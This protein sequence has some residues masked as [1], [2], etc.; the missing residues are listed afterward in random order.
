TASDVV[1]IAGSDATFGVSAR[2][3]H[4]R[5]VLLCAVDVVWKVVVECDA[6]KLRGWLILLCPTP[7]AVEGNIRTTVVTFDHAVRIV[8]SNP[9]MV[10]I[11]GR[12]A[13]AGESPAAIVGSIEA[14]I[15]N[16]NRID[17]LRIGVDARVVPG[18]L[19][20]PPFFVNSGPA[21]AAVV[22]TKDAAVFSL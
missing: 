7:A 15:Q 8:G 16:V 4:S 1:P 5:V 17:V 11:T 9:R 6:I 14:G 18:A 13:E 19:A 21:C 10:V 3:A 20:Q 22:G 12:T 2:D